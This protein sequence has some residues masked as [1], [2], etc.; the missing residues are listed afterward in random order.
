MLIADALSRLSPEEE[1]PIPDVYVHH[2]S[3]VSACKIRS[4]QKQLKTLSFLP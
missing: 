3:Q 4:E 1:I 2:N